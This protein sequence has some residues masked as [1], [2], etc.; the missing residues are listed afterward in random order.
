MCPVGGCAA[1]DTPRG[2]CSWAIKPRRTLTIDVVS[3]VL[4][5]GCFIGARRLEEALAAMPDVTA[6]GR[7]VPFQLD[8]AT[9]E[10]GADLRE[11]LRAKYRMDPDRRFGQVGSAARSAGIPPDSAK[12][13]PP[14]PTA[15]SPTSLP[16]PQPR[17]PVL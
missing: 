1:M 5:P 12:V 9:P 16:P 8:P 10:G 4:G 3:D 7:H 15:A 11:R 2:R 13:R 6:T 17:G 14:Y